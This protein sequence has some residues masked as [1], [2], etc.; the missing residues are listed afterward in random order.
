M[1]GWGGGGLKRGGAD[2]RR[3]RPGEGAPLP[4]QLGGMGERCKLPHR[5]LGRSPRIQRILRWKTLQNYAMKVSSIYIL[6]APHMH[7]HVINNL[8]NSCTN[9]IIT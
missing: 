7:V 5:G 4:L 2:C 9:A 6:H 8:V 1:D 3:S